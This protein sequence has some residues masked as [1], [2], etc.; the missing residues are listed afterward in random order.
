MNP[1]ALAPISLT[2]LIRGLV[3]NRD[4]IGQM[5]KRD[6]TGRYKGSV[7][8][9]AWS[10]VNPILLLAVYTYVF[11]NVFKARWGTGSGD[12]RSQFAVMLF[13]G[14][15]VHSLFSETLQRAPTLILSNASYVKKIVFP[16]ETLPIMALCSALF[17]AAV[18]LVVLA[19]A[20]LFL[21]GGVPWTAIFIPLV[22]FPLIMLTLGVA[23]VLAWLGVYLR[24]IAQP[25]SL[26]MTILLFASPVFYPITAL[27]EDIRPWLWLNPLTF[28]IEQARLVMVFG[29]VPDFAGLAIY[30]CIAI[31]IAWMG[32][33]SFQKTR[34]GFANV[35]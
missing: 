34:K 25:I 31:A 7:I 33:A 23:W 5:V 1:N 15:I 29:Q 14:M 35:I 24:D 16:L 11:S 32:Y 6:I 3:R 12:D 13:V 8:G 21:S 20:L 4:L 10:L 18:S 2:S 19:I 30:G 26:A 9:V 28:V 17:H 22:L 27:P